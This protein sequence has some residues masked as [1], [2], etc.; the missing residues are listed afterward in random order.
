VQDGGAEDSVDDAVRP[1]L[2]ALERQDPPRVM[3]MAQGHEQSQDKADCSSV[4]TNTELHTSSQTA[5][6]TVA[7]VACLIV[8]R[9]LICQHPKEAAAIEQLS[10]QP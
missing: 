2:A 10:Y 9:H 1:G 4:Y 7:A 3:P 6:P 5:L 8:T